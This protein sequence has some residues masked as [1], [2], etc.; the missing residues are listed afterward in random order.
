[1]SNEATCPYCKAEF[2]VRDHYESGE[3]ECP[4]C[5]KE[6]WVEVEYE[7]SY[8]ASCLDEDHDFQPA[9]VSGTKFKQ[10][11]RCGCVQVNGE[12]SP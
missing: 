8:D 1:M 4:E 2:E 6:I 11:S 9:I 7:V 12:E 3:Y 5:C 10:C